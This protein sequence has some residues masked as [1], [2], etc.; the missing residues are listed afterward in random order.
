MT[1]TGPGRT[2]Y[3]ITIARQRAQPLG[4]SWRQGDYVI[5]ALLRLV[6][7]ILSLNRPARSIA[8]EVELAPLGGDYS[9]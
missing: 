4:H 9:A 8:R 5:A 6:L 2:E 7:L 3:V 1:L